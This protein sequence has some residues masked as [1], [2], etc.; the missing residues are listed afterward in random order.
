ML[1]AA[2]TCPLWWVARW[3]ARV[4]ASFAVVAALALGAGQAPASAASS[5]APAAAPSAFT[6]GPLAPS[7][8]SAAVD[9]AEHA[10]A[11]WAAETASTEWSADPQPVPPGVLTVVP[12]APTGA[13]RV[14]DAG[15]DPLPRTDG[16]ASR[17]PRAPPAR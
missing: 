8:R 10:T 12:A 11:E 6:P 2:L 15:A 7:C 13:T 3:A 16:R 5:V 17:A 14:R 9:D 1:P 4:L